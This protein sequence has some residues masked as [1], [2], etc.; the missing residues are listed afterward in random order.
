MTQKVTTMERR[1][2]MRRRLHELQQ[3]NQKA[4]E[5]ILRRGQEIERLKAMTQVLARDLA[6]LAQG[7]SQQAP[8]CPLRDFAQEVCRRLGVQ[9]PKPAAQ[10]LVV[11]QGGIASVKS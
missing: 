1:S 10:G 6:N 8:P 7:I 5:E 2:D 4:S 9:A 3:I 11:V